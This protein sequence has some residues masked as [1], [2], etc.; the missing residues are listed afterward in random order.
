MG[1]FGSFNLETTCNGN[2]FSY[3]FWELSA[4]LEVFL[5]TFSKRPQAASRSAQKAQLKSFS[6]CF[7]FSSAFAFTNASILIVF[8]FS[9]ASR[10]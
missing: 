2:L 6:N 10:K 1:Y 7:L 5:G 4:P 9:D 8:P 3:V